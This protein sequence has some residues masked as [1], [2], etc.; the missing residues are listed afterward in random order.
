MNCGEIRPGTVASAS[1]PR[2]ALATQ[3]TAAAALA[4]YGHHASI[5]G[6]RHMR[7]HPLHLCV[8]AVPLGAALAIAACSSST[9]FGGYTVTYRVG[10][11]SVGIATIDSV[12]YDNGMGTTVKVTGPAVTPTAPYAVSLTVSPGASVE[13]HAY[14]SGVTAGH[15]A[16][17]VVVWMTATGALSGDS[18]TATTAA[19]T[20]FVLDLSKRTL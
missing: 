19:A 2:V 16:K 10:I 14:M 18:T 6:G 15:T 8:W 20:K 4:T 17:F 3:G 12:K 1:A 5:I 13:A 7:R 11:D 9:D